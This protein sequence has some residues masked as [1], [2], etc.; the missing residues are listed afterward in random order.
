MTGW[1]GLPAQPLFPDEP[2]AVHEHFPKLL[3][4]HAFLCKERA[5][6]KSEL[7]MEKQQRARC[8]GK[9]GLM[10]LSHYFVCVRGLH[11]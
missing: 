3:Q 6:L 7:L 9:G 2:I 5:V 1:K 10:W 8:A 11:D 4:L